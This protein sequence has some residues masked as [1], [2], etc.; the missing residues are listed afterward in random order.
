MEASGGDIAWEETKSDQRIGRDACRVGKTHERIRETIP[1]MILDSNILIGYLNGDARII[2]TLQTWRESGTV[3]FIS[4][5]SA[6]EVLSLSSLT[7]NDVA[8]IEKFLDDFIVI[9][10]DMRLIGIAGHLRRAFRVSV[11]DAAIV[12]TAITNHLPLVTRDKKLRAI[13]GIMLADI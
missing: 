1:S 8:G 9:P 6:I 2:A 7:S 12:A 11:P 10:V 13:P 4:A 3:L 5:T